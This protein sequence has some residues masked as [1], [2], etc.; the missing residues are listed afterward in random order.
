L[1][2]ETLVSVA[3]KLVATVADL[4][5]ANPGVI[6]NIFKAGRHCLPAS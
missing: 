3:E 5:A 2:G 6:P 4:L 1:Q